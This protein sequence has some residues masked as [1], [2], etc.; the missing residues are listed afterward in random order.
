MGLPCRQ[1]STC[2]YALSYGIIRLDGLRI[3]FKGTFAGL[4]LVD[5][6]E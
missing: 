4:Y 2:L 5:I 6:G 1:P 3:Y